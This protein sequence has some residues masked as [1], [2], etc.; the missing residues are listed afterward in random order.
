MAAHT[1]ETQYEKIDRRLVMDVVV[2]ADKNETIR[3]GGCYTM[4]LAYAATGSVACICFV[5]CNLAKSV[6]NVVQL[7]ANSYN[8]HVHYGAVAAQVSDSLGCVVWCGCN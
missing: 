2:L 3:Y 7:L 1:Y 5:L 6:P 8:E 4:G